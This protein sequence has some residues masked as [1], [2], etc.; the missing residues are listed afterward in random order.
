MGRAFKAP[1]PTET[2]QDS[3]AVSAVPTLVV[4]GAKD[5][6]A[7]HTSSICRSIAHSRVSLLPECGHMSHEEAPGALVGTLMGFVGEALQEESPRGQLL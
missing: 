4:V 7:T 3:R 2:A 5:K 6:V 1:S